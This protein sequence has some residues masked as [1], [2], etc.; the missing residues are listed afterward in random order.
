MGEG[1]TNAEV[2]EIHRRYGFFLRRRCQV[3]MRDRALADDAL[4][5]VLMKLLRHGAPFRDAP[6][7]MRWLHRVT[8]HACFDLFRRGKRAREA[9]PIDEAEELVHPGVSPE[10]RRAVADALAVLTEEEQEVAVMAFVDG[11]S[12]QEIADELGYSRVTVNKR[13]AA[14]R[15]RVSAA[16]AEAEEERP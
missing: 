14:I 3:L 9:A 7:P 13:V 10:L 1:L 15:R 8:D 11:M 4:Q 2:T 12:Q 5:E 6:H 16:Q